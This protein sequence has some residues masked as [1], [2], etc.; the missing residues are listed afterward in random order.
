MRPPS[1]RFV[2][3]CGHR[4]LFA[5]KRSVILAVKSTASPDRYIHHAEVAFSEGIRWVEG[6]HANGTALNFPSQVTSAEASWFGPS[7]LFEEVEEEKEV[8]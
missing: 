6:R 7:F 1:N 4:A 8:P 5:P 2:A 3:V